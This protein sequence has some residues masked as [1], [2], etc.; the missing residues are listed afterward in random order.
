MK[1]LWTETEQIEAHL[2]GLADNGDALLF[3][4]KRLLNPAL[5]DK[6]TWQQKTY[7]LINNYGRLQLKKEIEAVHNELFTQKQHLSFSQKIR[8]LFTKP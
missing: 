6:V 3:E 4:A 2:L 1:T 8:Q 5:A 7:T